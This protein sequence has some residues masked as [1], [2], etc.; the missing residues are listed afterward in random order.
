MENVVKS[1]V[2]VQRNIDSERQWEGAVQGLS[3]MTH[4]QVAQTWIRL[5]AAFMKKDEDCCQLLLTYLNHRHLFE[6]ALRDAANRGL[7]FSMHADGGDY[8][9]QFARINE[10]ISKSIELCGDFEGLLY[11]AHHTRE[12]LKIDIVGDRSEQ[13]SS[14][15]QN[16]S[17]AASGAYPDASPQYSRPSSAPAA[18]T[19]RVAP[20]AGDSLRALLE[21][22]CDE[23]KA[24][25]LA[26]D[27]RLDAMERKL[28][29]I[30]TTRLDVLEQK[31]DAIA[32]TRLEIP[33]VAAQQMQERV[34]EMGRGLDKHV[35]DMEAQLTVTI[36]N[37]LKKARDTAGDE[38]R[39]LQAHLDGRIN[40]VNTS[41]E[42][43]FGLV[44]EEMESMRA[45]VRKE[46]D[47]MHDALEQVP[48]A[49]AAAEGVA[50]GAPAA[51]VSPE[52][53]A[54]SIGRRGLRRA[55]SESPPRNSP[56]RPF[57]AGAAPDPK[58]ADNALYRGDPPVRSAFD[59]ELEP[60]DT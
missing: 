6:S 35:Q 40:N 23:Q 5:V 38:L 2:N 41:I 10:C 12:L 20:V 28:D 37:E 42:E 59:Y 9:D 50:G 49:P 1:L 19:P 53:S 52:T 54:N 55:S 51:G 31:L 21:K 7:I 16:Q 36:A 25:Q 13:D 58:K 47:H 24:H 57:R 3:V 46:M 45:E 4:L 11:S 39:Q 17:P 56:L 34:N 27:A 33:L 29:A 30:A 32:A 18:S 22:C 26:M 43:K 8:D 15:S 44:Q 14:A 60:W 48:E